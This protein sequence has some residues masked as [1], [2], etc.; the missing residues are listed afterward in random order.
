MTRD[1]AELCRETRHCP[2]RRMWQV[3]RHEPLFDQG[4]GT[5][6]LLQDF[7][8]P[9]VV[10]LL[11]VVAGG[12]LVAGVRAVRDRPIVLKRS[13][14]CPSCRGRGWVLDTYDWLP[15]LLLGFIG[16]FMRRKVPCPTCRGSGSLA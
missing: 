3:G 11:L 14:I 9:L 8:E 1:R 15:V 16:F 5:V 2:A 12:V 13:D 6:T 4:V 10:A 7:S